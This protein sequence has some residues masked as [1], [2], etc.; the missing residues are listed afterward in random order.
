M[1]Q[2]IKQ[3]LGQR[4][5]IYRQKLGLTQEQFASEADIDYKYF[6]R[7]E[8]RNP[9]NIGIELIEKIAK[10]LKLTPSKLLDFK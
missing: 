3:K 4:I 10:T 7:I 8:G 1:N 9:P 2:N 6:Q 5:K